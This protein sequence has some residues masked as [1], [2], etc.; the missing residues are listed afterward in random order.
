MS[1]PQ[2]YK[3]QLLPRQGELTAWALTFLAA[4]G[5]YFLSLRSPLPTWAWFFF[6]LLAFSAASLS[7]G[8]WMDRKTF[9]RLEAGGVLFENGLRKTR[10]TWAG[11]EEVRTA[12]ARWGTSVQVLGRQAHFSFSTLG[13]MRFQGQTRGQT[14]FAEGQLI[15]DE[16]LRRA[17]LTKA[18]QSGQFCAYLRQDLK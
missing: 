11:I 10:L 6:L 17:G 15:L 13:E 12:P 5:L 7:L 18:T 2:T 1:E 9:I 16:I 4:L 14:G 8:N 3:P